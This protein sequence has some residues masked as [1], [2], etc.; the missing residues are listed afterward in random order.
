MACSQNPGSLGNHPRLHWHFA[1][2]QNTKPVDGVAVFSRQ[3]W[4]PNRTIGFCLVATSQ[5][6]MLLDGRSELFPVCF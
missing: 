2:S 5:V 6:V 1:V 4:P 3:W